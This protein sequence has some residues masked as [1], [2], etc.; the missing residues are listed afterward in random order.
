MRRHVAT[1]LESMIYEVIRAGHD[2]EKNRQKLV[3]ALIQL[4]IGV[5]RSPLT[6]TPEMIQKPWADILAT[7]KAV[8]PQLFQKIRGDAHLSGEFKAFLGIEK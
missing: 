1:A 5:D 4:K 3:S 2:Y 6:T 7:Y 8:Y